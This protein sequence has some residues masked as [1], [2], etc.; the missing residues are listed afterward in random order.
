M[1]FHMHLFLV[2]I[3]QSCFLMESHL[4]VLFFSF[5]KDDKL[6]RLWVEACKRV[7]HD[8]KHVTWVPS[9]SDRLCSLHFKQDCFIK[10]SKRQRLRPTSVPS[11]FKF[12]KEERGPSD[13]QIRYEASYAQVPV[14]HQQPSTSSSQMQIDHYRSKLH[15]MRRREKRIRSTVAILQ[16]K[17]RD[18]VEIKE[19]LLRRLEIFKGM[20]SFILLVQVSWPTLQNF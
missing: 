15:N 10:N 13:R 8:N 6:K 12:S 5:P 18:E 11:I 1:S 19:S 20:L 4:L 17:L 7:K 9:N 14:I 3:F 2:I 16:Q